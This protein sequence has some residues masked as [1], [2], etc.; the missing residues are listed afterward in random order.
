MLI[1]TSTVLSVTWFGLESKRQK[2]PKIFYAEVLKIDPSIELV[3]SFADVEAHSER[4]VTWVD[5]LVSGMLS[6]EAL[7]SL[8]VDLVH[9][10]VNRHQVEQFSDIFLESLKTVYGQSWTTGID[11][12]WTR[13][14]VKASFFIQGADRRRYSV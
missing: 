1:D 8:G 3:F 4:F 2:L 5:Q 14:V 13:M 11:D 6:R 10:G 9:N 12:A 7:T